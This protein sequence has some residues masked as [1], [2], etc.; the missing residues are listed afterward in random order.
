M[1]LQIRDTIGGEIHQQLSTEIKDGFG[2]LVSNYLEKR[3]DT[4]L[5]KKQLEYK[6]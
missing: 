3:I 6:E 5:D 2:K 4:E 1:Y